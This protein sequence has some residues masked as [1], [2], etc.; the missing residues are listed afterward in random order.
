EDPP[1]GGTKKKAQTRNAS[2]LS[3]KCLAVTRLRVR[4]SANRS[5]GRRP[6][7]LARQGLRAQRGEARMKIHRPAERR[8]KPRRGMHLGFRI[9]AWR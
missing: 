8:K 1:P 6:V 5:F 2:G 3:N 9:N 7:E 4:V